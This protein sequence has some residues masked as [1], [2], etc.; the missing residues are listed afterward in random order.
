MIGSVGTDD[1][2]DE[3]KQTVENIFNSGGGWGT[4]VFHEICPGPDP[5][6]SGCPLEDSSTTPEIFEGLTDWLSHTRLRAAAASRCRPS[7]R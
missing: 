2:L 6:T 4:L 3:L 7:S 1:T 5:Q